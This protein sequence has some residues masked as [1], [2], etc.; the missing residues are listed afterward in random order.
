MNFTKK[1]LKYK[2]KFLMLA[3]SDTGDNDFVF[4]NNDGI[5]IRPPEPVSS[6]PVPSVPS[7]PVPSRPIPRMPLSHGRHAVMEPEPSDSLLRIL[8]NIQSPSITPRTPRTSLPE[9]KLNPLEIL[10]KIPC[11][12]NCEYY[13]RCFVHFKYQDKS[14]LMDI[15][16]LKENGRVS[17]T[18][19][20]LYNGFI[21][22][23][24]NNLQEH[25]KP[26]I[27]YK[28]EPKNYFTADDKTKN[29]AK[30]IPDK[31]NILNDLYKYL[32]HLKGKTYGFIPAGKL[33]YPDPT[34]NWVY[35]PD[36]F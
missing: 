35:K 31:I 1:Y 12:I 32:G 29:G 34:N 24:I 27:L 6:V 13:D 2:K 4:V 9:N 18:Q 15:N 3:G 14:Y 20:D 30:L 23:D 22:D 33:C 11:Q 16:L 7:V 5:E 21:N 36:I 28:S 17:G 10:K 19:F 26:Y 25:R 8:L